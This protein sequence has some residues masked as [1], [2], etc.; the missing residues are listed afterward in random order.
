MGFNDKL[1]A[2]TQEQMTKFLKDNLSFGWEVR[3]E[4]TENG[5]SFAHHSGEH[6]RFFPNEQIAGNA[7]VH[8]ESWLYDYRAEINGY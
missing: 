6:I 2:F 1:S 4:K 3:V 7:A 8:I 5:F